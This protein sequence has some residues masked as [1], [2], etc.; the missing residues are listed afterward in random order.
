MFQNWQRYKALVMQLEHLN[1]VSFM[2]LKILLDDTNHSPSHVLNDA[3]HRGHWNSVAITDLC[4][5]IVQEG[6]IPEDWKSSV[7]L[8][9]YKGKGDPMECGSYRRITLLKHAVKVV[10]SV[11]EH[12]IIEGR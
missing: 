10:E 2:F 4:N 8:P 7:L 5:G 3:S 11:F 12:R 6:C 9:F 1:H